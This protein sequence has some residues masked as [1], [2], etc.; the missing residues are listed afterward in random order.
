M[1]NDKAIRT[2][3]SHHLKLTK[4]MCP[5]TQEEYKMSKIPYALAIGSLMYAM[6]CTR[7]DVA[8]VVGVVSKYMSHPGIKHWN[9]FKW[10]LRY[11]RGAFS[12]CLHF[13]VSTTN[14]QGYIDSDLERKIDTRKST[15]GYV[16]IGCGTIAN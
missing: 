11:L 5:K 14:L 12:K 8:H 15:I 3:L 4:E 9:G 7:L 10:I 6:I 16:F 13:G 2:S 1:E